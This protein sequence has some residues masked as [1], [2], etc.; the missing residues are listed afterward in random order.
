V[1]TAQKK[2][3]EQA[4]RTSFDAILREKFTY[5]ARKVLF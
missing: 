1:A 3:E 4:L 2:K 5:L